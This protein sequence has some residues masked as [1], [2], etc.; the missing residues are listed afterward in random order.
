MTPG[1]STLLLS[2]FHA[3]HNRSQSARK[4]RALDALMMRARETNVGEIVL[5]G[6]IADERPAK[7]HVREECEMLRTSIDG[8][9]SVFLR[10]NH[11]DASYFETS[12]M[13]DLLRC[14]IDERPWHVSQVSG[15]VVTHGHH[16]RTPSIR[17]A[18]REASHAIHLES[19]F[20][21]RAV[22]HQKAM[23][24]GFSFAGKVGVS[25]EEAGFPATEL[26][27]DLQQV[28]QFARARIAG[29]LRGKRRPMLRRLRERFADAIDL[30]STRHAARLARAMGSWGIVSGH[31]HVPGLYKHWLED[32]ATG[33]RVPF[34]VGNSGSFV[35]RYAP[36]FIEVTHPRM[37]LWQFDEKTSRAVIVQSIEL[38]DDEL[39]AQNR[40]FGATTA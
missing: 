26:W 18:L 40:F 14:R 25:L 16:F 1:S 34:L 37:T 38:T 32:D 4:R 31:T 17:R 39:A 5:A 23:N 7:E 20:D 3:G 29:T 15:V 13:E 24:K 6:D 36:T 27:E 30:R 33:E 35:S 12:E 8:Y 19:L 21:E 10:G 2:D 11:D 22:R 28:S 9:A